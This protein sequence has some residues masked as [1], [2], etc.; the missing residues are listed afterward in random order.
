MLLYGMLYGLSAMTDSSGAVYDVH[1]KM[2]H[3]GRRLHRDERILGSL[4]PAPRLLLRSRSSCKNSIVI[5]VPG[6]IRWPYAAPCSRPCRAKPCDSRRT[7]SDA[8]EKR[9]ENVARL[10]GIGYGQAS[11]YDGVATGVYLVAKLRCQTYA[12]HY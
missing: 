4:Q 7:C 8:S 12:T 5:D 1:Y 10:P 2:H 11:M 9:P 6:L 3:T